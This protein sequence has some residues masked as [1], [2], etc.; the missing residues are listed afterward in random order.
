MN[1]SIFIVATVFCLA[2]LGCSN[3][4]NQNAAGA[5]NSDT[6][7]E[8][9]YVSVTDSIG[10]YA[11]WSADK[12]YYVNTAIRVANGGTLVIP[13]GTIV[14][15][16]TEGSLSVEDGGVLS[17]QGSASNPIYF[18]SAKDSRGETVFVGTAAAGDWEGIRVELGSSGSVFSNCV[19]C[20][21]GKNMYAALRIVGSA[22]VDSCLFR[23]N[24][25][26]HPTRSDV[27]DYATLDARDA[28]SGTVITNN[29]FYRNLWP[30]AVSCGFNLSASNTF[31][32]DEDN[33]AATPVVTNTQQAIYMDYGDISSAVSWLETEVPLCTFSNLIRIT[34]AA[35]LTI[36]NGAV[37][38]NS[39]SEF[40]VEENG[41]L[42][43]A[44][45]I[46]TSYRD[47]NHGG[48]TNGDG[49]VTSPQKGDWT[50]IEVFGTDGFEY[51]ADETI[52]YAEQPTT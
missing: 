21:G 27:N 12:T 43:R 11:T 14:K 46:F 31:S 33:N 39:T 30:L 40:L 13:A 38:K 45:A 9:K 23:D 51:S 34:S 42:N 24:I 5:G 32:C 15:F 49:T 22:S 52:L 36:A 35:S 2:M 4:I 37:I 18:T 25:G 8:T 1:K 20:Y 44:G 16:G 50:G 17:A 3:P 10:S 47:D 6:T 26:G 28:Q 7:G 48:D 29:L 19:F 41:V